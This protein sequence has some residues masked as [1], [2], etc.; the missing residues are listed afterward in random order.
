MSSEHEQRSQDD[1]L[2]VKAK[3]KSLREVLSCTR[4]V[5]HDGLNCPLAQAF[6]L[7]LDTSC[8]VCMYV[9][10]NTDSNKKK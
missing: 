1:K 6:V 5:L 9:R 4:V 3:K 7:G 8:D 2:G 10:C